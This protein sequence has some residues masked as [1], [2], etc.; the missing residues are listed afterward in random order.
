MFEEESN[1]LQLFLG[2]ISRIKVSTKYIQWR[3]AFDVDLVDVG[4]MGDEQFGN[5]EF[6]LVVGMEG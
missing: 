4:T 2:W 5:P 3:F 1:S 6:V